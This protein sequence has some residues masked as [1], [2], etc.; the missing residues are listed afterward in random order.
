MKQERRQ[1]FDAFLLAMYLI[2][3]RAPKNPNPDLD[4]CFDLGEIGSDREKN[5]TRE[6]GPH[7]SALP[8]G[9]GRVIDI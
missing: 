5:W 7:S 6:Q 2:F 8:K 9:I 3:C 1:D 4:N